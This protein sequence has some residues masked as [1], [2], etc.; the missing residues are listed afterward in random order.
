[1]VEHLLPKCHCLLWNLAWYYPIFIT[2]K[3]QLGMILNDH[4]GCNSQSNP[5]ELLALFAFTTFHLLREPNQ[6]KLRI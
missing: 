6:M 3:N 5:G 1:M 2:E 4:L